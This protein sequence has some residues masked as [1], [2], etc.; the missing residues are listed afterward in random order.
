MVVLF[1]PRRAGKHG[2]DEAIPLHQTGMKDFPGGILPQEKLHAALQRDEALKSV[3]V[4]RGERKCRGQ[5]PLHGMTAAPSAAFLTNKTLA[6]EQRDAV[7]IREHAEM[8]VGA[9]LEPCGDLGVVTF[10]AARAATVYQDGA[11]RGH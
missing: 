8:T 6:V 7:V 5:I 9:A 4:A 11:Q 1:L 3:P 2:M 10:G